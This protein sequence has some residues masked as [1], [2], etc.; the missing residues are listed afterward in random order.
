MS[1]FKTDREGRF[2]IPA[3]SPDY[4]FTL[5]DGARELIVGDGLVGGEAK[6]LGDVRMKAEGP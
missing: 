5:S 1:S 2:R 4:E 3:M 6:D